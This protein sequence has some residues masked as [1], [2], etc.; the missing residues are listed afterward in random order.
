MFD[1]WGDGVYINY[2]GVPEIV[3]PV[4]QVEYWSAYTRRLEWQPV[5]IALGTAKGRDLMLLGLVE[6]LVEEGLLREVMAG[7]IANPVHE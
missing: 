4:R 3:V 1:G 6:R 5:T 7:E 2:A